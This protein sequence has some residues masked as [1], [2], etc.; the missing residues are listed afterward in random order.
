MASIM[1][2][3]NEDG[4]IDMDALGFEGQ[5]CQQVLEQLVSELGGKITEQQLKKEY[6]LR[7]AKGTVTNRAQR[8]ATQ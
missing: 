1:I 3:L 5:V 8:K 6:H 4:T 7:T 2:E